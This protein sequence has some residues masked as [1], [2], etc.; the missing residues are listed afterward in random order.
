M[1]YEESI[2]YLRENS[3]SSYEIHKATGLS[4]AGLR[5]VLKGKIT[6]PQR[7]TKELLIDYVNQ[8]DGL[9]DINE[10][11]LNTLDIKRIRTNLHLTQTDLGKLLGVGIRTVQLWE[12]GE[13]NMT[14]TTNKLLNELILKENNIIP[15]GLNDINESDFNALDVKKMN[16]DI[17]AQQR[18]ILG[19]TWDY[20]AEGLP[21]AGNS[22]RTAFNRRA[23]GEVY[24]KHVTCVIDDYKKK[25]VSTDIAKFG[26]DI[27]LESYAS[28]VMKNHEKLL[29]S[30][31]YKNW[32]ELQVYKKALEVVS[33]NKT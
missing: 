11:D 27:V 2:K 30:Q 13:R 6:K 8:L 4:E 25:Q 1:N 31:N 14:K 15:D 20:L 5:K 18:K 21:I 29:L 3:H 12:S 17:I 10:S 22:L 33:N 9:N 7:K 28:D 23:V 24:L 19:L 26:E 16:L 32:F